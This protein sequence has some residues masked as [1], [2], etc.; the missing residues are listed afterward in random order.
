[1]TSSWDNWKDSK[2]NDYQEPV[3]SRITLALLQDTGYVCYRYTMIDYYCTNR[4]YYPKYKYGFIVHWG[5]GKGCGFVNQSCFDWISEAK[6]N[7]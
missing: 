7:K 3:V 1:M 5:K 2:W 6:K 4:W